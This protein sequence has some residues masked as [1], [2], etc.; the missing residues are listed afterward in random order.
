MHPLHAPFI[1]Q[2]KTFLYS[3]Y[4]IMHF[5]EII[6]TQIPC[7]QN[8]FLEIAIGRLLMLSMDSDDDQIIMMQMYRTVKTTDKAAATLG[9]SYICFCPFVFFRSLFISSVQVNELNLRWSNR[10]V[11]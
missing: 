5:Y 6:I 7:M 8:Q 10:Y 4:K 9:I 11:R 3:L 1:C 2:D